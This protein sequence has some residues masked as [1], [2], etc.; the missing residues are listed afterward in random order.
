MGESLTAVQVLTLAAYVL[1]GMALA[2]LFVALAPLLA[3]YIV[4]DAL[5]DR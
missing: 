1:A 4:V 3:A 2:V 5:L